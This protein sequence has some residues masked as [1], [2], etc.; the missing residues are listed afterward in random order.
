MKCRLM[1]SPM[2]HQAKEYWWVYEGW[3]VNIKNK[4]FWL[5]ERI[6]GM[7]PEIVTFHI[8]KPSFWPDPDRFFLYGLVTALSLA[9]IPCASNILLKK[10][11]ADERLKYKIG[12]FSA[13]EIQAEG[14]PIQ[15]AN[16]TKLLD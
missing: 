9:G 13:E 16:Y 2:K 4:L 7:P 8:F 14:H 6:K 5:F 10:I 11:N 1:I 15:I 3:V 12:Y